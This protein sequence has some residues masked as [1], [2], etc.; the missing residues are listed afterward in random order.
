MLKHKCSCYKISII[1]R[2]KK[3]ASKILQ[4]CI[5]PDFN[6]LEVSIFHS[7]TNK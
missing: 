7:C 5:L 3:K 6:I 2:G 1:T 4:R